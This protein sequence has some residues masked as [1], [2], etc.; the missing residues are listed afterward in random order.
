MEESALETSEIVAALQRSES[1]RSR[2]EALVRLRQW[3]DPAGAVQKP[4]RDGLL[5]A[6]AWACAA[7]PDVLAT[8]QAE[9]M[10]NQVENGIR[11]VSDDDL[12]A[13][14]TAAMPRLTS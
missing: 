10:P 5:D 8:I 1:L 14:I 3:S 4:L 9:P 11:N 12:K 13:A 7:D 2:L 6:L